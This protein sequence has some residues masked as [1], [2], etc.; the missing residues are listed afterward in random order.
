MRDRRKSSDVR[1]SNLIQKKSWLLLPE[2]LMDL[3]HESSERGII[4]WIRIPDKPVKASP[5]FLVHPSPDTA[6]P[7]PHSSGSGKFLQANEE[8][9]GASNTVPKALWFEGESCPRETPEHGQQEPHW[10]RVHF[11]IP[12]SICS[13]DIFHWHTEAADCS[14]WLSLCQIGRGEHGLVF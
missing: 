10:E 12:R 14:W 6:L 13:G 5:S 7:D 4:I 3:W 9:H 8:I 11:P 1:R 2:R